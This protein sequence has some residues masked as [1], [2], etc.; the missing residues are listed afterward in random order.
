MPGTRLMFLSIVLL[1]S[2]KIPVAA[3]GVEAPITPQP[4]R[5]E[6]DWSLPYRRP[7]PPGYPRHT[8]RAH[9][10]EQRLFMAHVV[11]A[12][13]TTFRALESLRGTDI[14]V[15]VIDNSDTGT[16]SDAA[17]W[18]VLQST[19]FP[20]SVVTPVVPLT[21]PQTENAIQWLAYDL[22]LDIFWTMHSEKGG[23]FLVWKISYEWNH[24]VLRR[25]MVLP[26]A[27]SSGFAD[28]R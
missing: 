11:D 13:N 5:C 1:V 4:R 6:H 20:V 8:R 7:L 25:T 24:T 26:R 12:E 9:E 19:G 27:V 17:S 28:L 16:M 21:H 23:R 10:P 18:T 14:S 22:Q 15:V 2:N 3:Q